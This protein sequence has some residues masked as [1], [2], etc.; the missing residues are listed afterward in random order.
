MDNWIKQFHLDGLILKPVN[1]TFIC[2]CQHIHT[3]SKSFTRLASKDELF[4]YSAQSS[5]ISSAA[6]KNTYN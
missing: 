4:S 3:L 6:N 5:L 1:V 2:E